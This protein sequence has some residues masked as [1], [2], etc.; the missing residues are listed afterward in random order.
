MTY[1][2]KCWDLADH[3]LDDVAGSTDQDRDALAREIQQT[4]EGFCAEIEGKAI[5]SGDQVLA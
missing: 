2:Q 3:F 1:D 4:I 5:S